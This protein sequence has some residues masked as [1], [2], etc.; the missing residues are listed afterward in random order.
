MRFRTKKIISCRV[1]RVSVKKITSLL[2]KL[3]T[4][5]TRAERLTSKC[6]IKQSSFFLS[7][8]K[9]RTTSKRTHKSF[10]TMWCLWPS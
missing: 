8:T 3:K 6:S 7:V 10:L 4:S 1:K 5:N 9:L 2:P